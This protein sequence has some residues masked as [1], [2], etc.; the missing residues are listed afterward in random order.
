VR[1]GGS[2]TEHVFVEFSSCPVALPQVGGLFQA[3]AWR[4]RVS[5]QILAGSAVSPAAPFIPA[6]CFAPVAAAV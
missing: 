2:R 1:E 4:Q 5:I 6:W 3:F